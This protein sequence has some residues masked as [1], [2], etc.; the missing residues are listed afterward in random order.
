[1]SNYATFQR[2]RN[3]LTQATVA[4]HAGETIAWDVK[5]SGL[6]P[7][8][9]RNQL[10]VVMKNY[11]ASPR[12]HDPDIPTTTVQSILSD[13]AMRETPHGF[14]EIGPRRY[15]SRAINLDPSVPPPIPTPDNACLTI[16]GTNHSFVHAIAL[17]KNHDQIPNSVLL[18]D[19]DTSLLDTL[20]TT[21]P[22]IE[23]IQDTIAGVQTPNYIL[24]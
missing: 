5:A 20:Y 22:N 17:L 16:D 14:V 3:L 24:I 8:Y 10:R 13:W 7:A 15:P 23:L 18:T 21:Y 12:W 1:M 19:F 2:F 11:L 6:S 9:V 4:Y